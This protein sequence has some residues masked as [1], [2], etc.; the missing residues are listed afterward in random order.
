MLKDSASLY[1]F[2]YLWS[3]HHHH[4]SIKTEANNV[5]VTRNKS[6]CV[7]V[8]ACSEHALEPT[9]TKFH[10]LHHPSTLVSKF[11]SEWVC[12]C[13]CVWSENWK[14]LKTITSDKR[15]QATS[16]EEKKKV[17]YWRWWR[18]HFTKRSTSQKR[19]NSLLKPFF[20]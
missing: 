8:C 11:M 16:E 4:H 17:D 12:V 20:K 15:L 2:F 1:V 19:P 14:S 7:C 3:H 13:V 5:N 18:N 9:F 6:M 10:C